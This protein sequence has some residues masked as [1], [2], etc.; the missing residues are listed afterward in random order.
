MI[1]NGIAPEQIQ[2][3]LQA[4]G[5]LTIAMSFGKDVRREVYKR[6]KGKCNACHEHF[7]KLQTHHRT[8]HSLGGP[9][10]IDNAVGLCPEDHH[11]ADILAFQGIIYPQ[12]HK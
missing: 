3:G 11:E 9:D 10:T 7:D 6:Q 4:L 12:V 2:Y 5:L 8:P 1:E